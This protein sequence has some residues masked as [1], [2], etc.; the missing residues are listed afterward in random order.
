MKNF[1]KAV[2]FLALIGVI[3]LIM[4]FNAAG[5]VVMGSLVANFRLF[6]GAVD[7]PVA[8]EALLL[9]AVF[10]HM[11]L[12]VIIANLLTLGYF[13]V[14]FIARKDNFIDYV[15]FR[16][17]KLK[18]GILVILLGVFLNF[19]IVVILNAV[20]NYLPMPIIEAYAEVMDTLVNGSFIMILITGSIMAPLFEEIIIRGIVFNDFKKAVPVWL[21]IMIQAAVFGV[22]HMNIIQGTYAFVIGLIFGLVYLKYNSIWVPILM[23]F[24]FNTTSLF[25]DGVFGEKEITYFNEGMFVVGLLGIVAILS[26]MYK[27]HIENIQSKK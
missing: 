10:D 3:Y 22:M 12:I 9:G 17:I 27:D 21:A 16:K 7:D 14:V 20:M 19:V 6:M 26:I 24:S 15:G 4:N 1:M 5:V 18:D 23:H 25:I 2:G 8:I 11:L 13:Y